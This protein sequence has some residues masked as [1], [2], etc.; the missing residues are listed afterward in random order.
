MSQKQDFYI[1][2]GS[3][4]PEVFL[5]VAEA[6]RYLET[7][8]E[9]TVN[10]AALRAG[11]SRS[12]F[13]KYRDAIRPFRDMFYGR[14]VTIQILLRDEPQATVLFL[15]FFVLFVPAPILLGGGLSLFL[16]N[17]YRKNRPP[18]AEEADFWKRQ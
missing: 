1:V 18:A 11:I 10:A 16:Y 4:L 7:G 13:Y 2:E 14:I 5:R 6:K 17:R 12:A 9:R 15:Q 3:V 8:E